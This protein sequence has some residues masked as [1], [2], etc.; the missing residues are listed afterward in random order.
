MNKISKISLCWLIFL[1]SFFCGFYV[2]DFQIWPYGPLSKIQD[3]FEGHSSEDLSLKEKVQND[4]NFKPSRHIKVV[5]RKE[6]QE[7]EY[8][9]INGL[10]LNSRR[11]KPKVFISDQA[12]EGYRVIYGTFDFENVLHGAIMLDSKGHVVHVWHISQEDLA[13]KSYDDTNVFPH[14]FEVASDGSIVTAYDSGS[15]LTKYDYCGDVIWRLKGSFHHSIEFEGQKAIWVWKDTKTSAG[16]RKCLTK[17]DYQT[18]DILK[19]IALQKIMEENPKIDIF[20]ILQKDTGS[21]SSWINEGGGRWHPNDI[22]PLPKT[23]ANHYPEF[24]TD[25][26]L[27]SLRSPNLIFILDQKTLKVKWW[28]QGLTRRQHDPDWNDKGTITVFNNNMHRG[29]SNIMEVNPNTYEYNIIL[30]GEKY[31]FYTW[32][33]GKHQMMPNGGFLVTS[34]EQGRVFETSSEGDITFE[35]INSYGENQEVL[36]ISEALFLPKNYFKELPQCE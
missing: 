10:N 25:N 28:R 33:R 8:E 11:K 26:L 4:F 34:S 20:G 22:D 7:V 6:D 32:W 16:W 36:A 5:N 19:E 12:P 24:N 3:F 21:G 1:F 2:Y 18:G 17:V 31:N 23:L 15:S 30:K 13:W 14:G 35:F 9:E 27:V 29:F